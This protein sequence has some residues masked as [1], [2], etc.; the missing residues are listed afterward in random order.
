M[1]GPVITRVALVCWVVLVTGLLLGPGLGGLLGRGFVLTYDMVWVPDLLLTRDALGLGVGLPRAVPSDAVVAVLDELVPAGALQALVLAGSLVAGGLGV[2]ALLEGEGLVARAVAATAYVWNPLVVER[3]LIGHWPLLVGYA[4]LPWLWHALRASGDRL[5]A[6]VWWLVPLGSLSASTGL[7]T[8]VVLLLAGARRVGRRWVALAG[9]CLLANAP[10]LVAGLLRV[11][12]ATSDPLGAEVFGLNDEGRVPGPVA[13]LTLG[14]IWNSEVVPDTRTGWLG[15]LAP[16]LWA[17]LVVPG[18]RPLRARLSER[19]WWTLVTAWVLGW[20]GASLTW[21]APG[22]VGEVAAVVPGGGVLRDGARL[23]VLC[24]PLLCL[25]A[26]AGAGRWCA[27]LPRPARP[28][29]VLAVLLLPFALLPDAALGAGG[30]LAPTQFPA[31]LG[32]ARDQAQDA[33]REGRL[34]EPALVL[35]FSAYRRPAWNADRPVLDPTPRYLGLDAVVEDTLRVDGRPVAGE[36]PLA[37]AVRAALGE[38]TAA[39]RAEALESL[40]IGAVVTESGAGPAPEVSGE[41]LHPGRWRVVALDPD[42]P[43]PGPGRSAVVLQSLA[44]LGF[45]TGPAGALAVVLARRRGS[46]RRGA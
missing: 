11:A 14:G 28:G 37:T 24:A 16:L 2:A 20:S 36:D 18:L 21:W 29:A 17:L 19:T 44:W 5:P 33:L 10:W 40:G 7:V 46:R 4:V 13:A 6:R 23:L 25:A 26:G 9:L 31:E 38:P 35:P 34:Q 32:V 27:A 1:G 42:G 41:T 12:S 8:A 39:R 3:L 30:R 22:L 15:V 45:L 43:V